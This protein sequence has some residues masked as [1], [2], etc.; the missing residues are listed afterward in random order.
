MAG[1]LSTATL[2]LLLTGCATTGPTQ[3]PR[4]RDFESWQCRNDLEVRCDE[5]ACTAE[6]GDGF[7]PMSVTVNASGGLSACAYSGCWEGLGRVF[8]D[9]PYLVVIG[10]DLEFSTAP[11]NE[12]A[13]QDVLVAIDRTDSVAIVKAGEFAHPLRCEPSE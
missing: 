6:P 8:R 5:E 3:H 11:G 9:E 10:R 12:S 13:R 2:A 4:E 7:T 1:R